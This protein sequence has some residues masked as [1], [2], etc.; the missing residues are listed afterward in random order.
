M[1]IKARTLT[2]GRTVYDVRLRDPEGKAY[3]RTF[4][5]Q[6]GCRSLRSGPTD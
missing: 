2:S 3:K 1:S 5:D 4:P 6:A